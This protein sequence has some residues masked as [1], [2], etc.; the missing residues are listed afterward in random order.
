MV[1]G[2]VENDVQMGVE[3]VQAYQNM[4]IFYLQ[5]SLLSADPHFQKTK[6]CC[7]TRK[8]STAKYFLDLLGCVNSKPADDFSGFESYECLIAVR[9][10]NVTR[11]M[12]YVHTFRT[13]GGTVG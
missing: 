12:I 10:D 5:F 11:N 13:G 3:S 6:L 9:G 1:K 7:K 2:H 4:L 8:P